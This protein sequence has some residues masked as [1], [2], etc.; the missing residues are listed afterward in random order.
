MENKEADQKPGNGTWVSK[1]KKI[2]HIPYAFVNSTKIVLFSPCRVFFVCGGTYETNRTM[3]EGWQIGSAPSPLSEGV[4]VECFHPTLS[5]AVITHQL[6]L[7]E[8]SKSYMML[9]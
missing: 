6:A 3:G 1:P 5:V 9:C 2:T 7:A 4:G 8:I